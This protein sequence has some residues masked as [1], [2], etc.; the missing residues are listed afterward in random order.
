LK[1]KASRWRLDDAS[2]I[3]LVYGQHVRRT[4]VPEM[5]EQLTLKEI[6]DLVRTEIGKSMYHDEIQVKGVSPWPF[7]DD[8]NTVI[9]E[10]LLPKTFDV[11]AEF[12]DFLPFQRN[13][14]RLVLDTDGRFPTIHLADAA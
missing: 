7:D 13:I 8:N 14:E 2:Q 12:Q 4:G 10:L 3:N 11:E 9:V 5:A 6:G 1:K